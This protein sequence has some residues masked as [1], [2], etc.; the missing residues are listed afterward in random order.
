MRY[1]AILAGIGVLLAVTGTAG[2]TTTVVEGITGAPGDWTY[3]YTLVNHEADPIWQ[4]A[5]WFPTDPQAN[6]VT[7]GSAHWDTPFGSTGYFPQQ[8]V[9]E[10]YMAYVYDSTADPFHAGT[11][12]LLVGPKGEPGYYGAYANDY[13]TTNSGEYWDGDS[14][15][16]LPAT[17]PLPADPLW[18]KFLRGS[19]YGYDFGWTEGSGGN[20]QTSYGIGTGATGQIIVKASTPL[21]GTKSFSFN[22][23]DYYYSITDWDNSAMY[24]DFEGSGTV[25]PEPVTMAGLMLGI[26]CLA[27][28]VRRRRA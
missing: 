7:T 10:G 4:W 27:R 22:T 24:L 20:V 18:D 19:K 28:Y 17:E 8:Y 6:S 25:I 14:W 15:E 1:I 23:T 11:P 2:A 16:A 13:M 26:G 12:N 21:A 9:A 5:V 3:T